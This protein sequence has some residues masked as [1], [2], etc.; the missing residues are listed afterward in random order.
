MNF[1][2]NDP[3]VTPPEP[4][5][6]WSSEGGCW[7]CRSCGG[8]AGFG[9]HG[10]GC[11]EQ[12]KLPVCGDVSADALLVAC[13]TC[14]KHRQ[15]GRPHAFK[16]PDP[17]ALDSIRRLGED[18]AITGYFVRVKRGERYVN[19]DITSLD[20]RELTEFFNSV[21][22]DKARKWAVGLAQWIRDNIKVSVT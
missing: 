6:E 4:W 18:A 10:P 14:G 16:T 19:I 7:S 12:N 5:N 3:S 21:G 17:E 20:D 13:E 11:P 9:T 2:H 15:A 8:A 22:A 1:V